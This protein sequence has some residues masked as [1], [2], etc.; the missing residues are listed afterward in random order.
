MAAK[1]RYSDLLNDIL[2]KKIGQCLCPTK[3][4]SS[5][6][7]EKPKVNSRDC[8]FGPNC[9]FSSSCAYNKDVCTCRPR[10]TCVPTTQI[11]QPCDKSICICVGT[12]MCKS[13]ESLIDKCRQ[14]LTD[15]DKSECTD[16]MTTLSE[17][18]EMLLKK[19]MPSSSPCD[20][21]IC[22]CGGTCLCK[23]EESLL[24]Q[25]YKPPTHSDKTK[26]CVCSIC[27]GRKQ[28]DYTD[29]LFPSSFR[30]TIKK[31][32]LTLLADENMKK[33]C[34]E[35][36][37][38]IT[39]HKEN[40][41]IEPEMCKL[42]NNCEANN[43]EVKQLYNPK[44]DKDTKVVTQINNQVTVSTMVLENKVS[45]FPNTTEDFMS[46]QSKYVQKNAKRS[47]TQSEDYLK[48]NTK[49]RGRKSHKKDKTEPKLQR[50]SCTEKSKS[51]TYYSCGRRLIQSRPP[52]IRYYYSGDTEHYGVKLG[53][54]HCRDLPQLVPKT[55]GWL[56]NL[57]DPGKGIRERK[58]WPP[59]FI[60]KNIK[61]MIQVLKKFNEQEGGSKKDE[62]HKKWRTVS[63]VDKK[64]E[65]KEEPP[66]IHIHKKGRVYNIT[67]CPKNSDE[68]VGPIPIP[69][70]I[71]QKKHDSDTESSE[72][73][74]EFELH[75]P[76]PRRKSNLVM[77]KAEDE[78]T[79]LK[80]DIEPGAIETLA[81]PPTTAKTTTT[82]KKS[83]KKKS[84]ENK[85]WED[86][87]T[88]VQKLNAK[89]KQDINN[90]KF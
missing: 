42:Q 50:S 40:M 31:E 74:L 48:R 90:D 35:I 7:Y 33:E 24:N 9:E 77:K 32:A 75:S 5:L 55:M 63:E 67:F 30:N 72:S 3:Y 10:C 54:K 70:S 8:Q 73:T 38:C 68:D 57:E 6:Q 85:N 62:V 16:A 89:E 13:E 69:F 37:K 52:H 45:I 82:K 34:A 47:Y 41:K 61:N 44:E 56:W 17:K 71:T 22:I 36:K 21:S 15:D 12:C 59:G 26:N 39:V 78:A 23:S 25:S 18:Q 51:L 46:P 87:P 86:Q 83:N 60:G 76:K 14:P 4:M 81:P 88:Q 79:K 65:H 53:H 43:K 20:K 11:T 84:D 58:G 1:L 29:D 64:S 2:E 19:Y 66:L 80:E 27:V 49:K 28:Q